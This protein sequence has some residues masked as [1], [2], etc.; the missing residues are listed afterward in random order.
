MRKIS[1]NL[2]SLFWTQFYGALNDN[3]FKSALVILITYK[4][5]SLF[6]VNTASM[7]A[8]CGGIFIFPFF[9]I[10]ATSGQL[11]DK[12]DKVWLSYRIKEAEVGI[13][14]LGSLGLL[15]NNY[16]LMLL[17]LFLLGLQSTF[18]GPIKYSLI[19]HYASKDQLI[20][21]NA[22]VSSG[23]FVAI[24][25]G[26][27]IGGVAA[28]LGDNRWPLIAILLVIAYLGLHYAKKLPL[29][30]INKIEREAM[31]IDWN[32]FTSTRDILKLVFKNPLIALLIIGLSWFWFLG[33]GLLSLLPL[34]A[35]DIFHGNENV[36]TMLLFTFTIGMGVGPFIL[37]KLTKGKIYRWVIPVSLIA[38][39]FVIFD[40]SFVI[41]G[42][43]KSSFLLSLSAPVS[44][45]EFFHLNMSVRVV[46]DLFLLSLF[47]GTFTVPQFAELQRIT[48]ETELSRIIAGNNVINAIAMVAVSVLLM[49]FHQ[50]HFSLSLIL[51]ILGVF[52]ILM[53]LVLVYFYKSEFNKFWRF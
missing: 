32:F 12:L 25:L 4:S 21:G 33:A 47:G 51:T 10:S 22:L 29:E 50:Q 26:T 53:C 1:A 13:A 6:G 3:L 8:L 30:G 46:F 20:F 31:V 15:F 9:F 14:I 23:T 19:P 28:S 38:M 48:K 49:I 5:I 11:A 7:V 45:R 44:V 41:A 18:F 2:N 42:A 40:L 17:V 34:M 16:Y 36:A 27:I 35:K 37:E 52:N 24:L 43:S 39:T